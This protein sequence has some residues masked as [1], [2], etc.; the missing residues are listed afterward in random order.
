MA[1]VPQLRKDWGNKPWATLNGRRQPRP[2]DAMA[3]LDVSAPSQSPSELYAGNQTADIDVLYDGYFRGHFT[4]GDGSVSEVNVPPGNGSS[5]MRI[6]VNYSG[7]ESTPVR[8]LPTGREYSSSGNTPGYRSFGVEE[9]ARYDTPPSRRS[10]LGGEYASYENMGIRHT[11]VSTSESLY[12]SSGSDTVSLSYGTTTGTTDPGSSDA[13][14]LP[15]FSSPSEDPGPSERR[16]RP[17]PSM[18]TSGR[19]MGAPPSRAGSV[20]GD[21]ASLPGSLAGLSR[22]EVGGGDQGTASTAAPVGRMRVPGVGPGSVREAGTQNG[23]GGASLPEDALQQGGQILGGLKQRLL[24]F[25]LQSIQDDDI[26]PAAV[27]LP[28]LR[29]FA[30]IKLFRS[31]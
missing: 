14:T 5:R 13:T 24:S 17:V 29:L 21:E 8:R 23:R 3:A 20:F 25:I 4:G 12:S 16:M 31:S 30:M 11:S 26:S 6:G 28:L 10:L 9:Y 18:S 7:Y 15:D 22:S 2:R 19:S 27:C 1:S